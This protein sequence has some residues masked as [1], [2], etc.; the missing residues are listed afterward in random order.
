MAVRTV[1]KKYLT[2][3]KDG[4]EL[5]MQVAH[6]IAPKAMPSY[7]STT[8]VLVLMH[9]DG[10]VEMYSH[11]DIRPTFYTLSPFAN[12]PQKRLHSEQLLELQLPPHLREMYYPAATSIHP[13]RI[14]AGQVK[15]R[16]SRGQVTFTWIN[17]SNPW[18]EQDE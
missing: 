3:T 2:S 9:P 8:P 12:T 6:E 15:F 10:W 13:G 16:Q 18:P 11:K 14:A 4:R 7:R 17:C 5:L 1:V